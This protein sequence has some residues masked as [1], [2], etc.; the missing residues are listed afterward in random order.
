MYEIILSDKVK[1][2][3]SKLSQEI[4]DRVG[5]VIERI[6][7]R[8]HYFVK[9]LVGSPYFR[10]RVGDYRLILDIQQDKLIILVLEI[11]HRK[12]TYN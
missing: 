8:P 4:K 5:N 1:N 11:G 7:I 3:L 12:N 2:Q 10:L 6:K 9:K